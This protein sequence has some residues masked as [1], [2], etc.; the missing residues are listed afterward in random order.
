[1]KKTNKQIRDRVGN[2]SWLNS[3]FVCLLDII[4]L[5]KIYYIGK[6]KPAVQSKIQFLICKSLC[7]TPG[8]V[9]IIVANT[10]LHHLTANH[11]KYWQDE[12]AVVWF[13]G[14]DGLRNTE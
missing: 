5:K 14:V 10:G 7:L 6:M 12:R 1:M 8:Q 13:S 9:I 2:K 4:R 11:M 3:S